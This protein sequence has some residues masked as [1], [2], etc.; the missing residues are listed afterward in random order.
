MVT[1]WI[2]GGLRGAASLGLLFGL[3]ANS[4]W[5]TK[6]VPHV[7]AA[8]CTVTAE[9]I[10][11]PRVKSER[12]EIQDLLA[13]GTDDVWVTG[14]WGD[15]A[16]SQ[17]AFVL[18]REGTQWVDRTPPEDANI[19]GETERQRGL[20]GERAED[21]ARAENLW[22]SGRALL[23][24]TSATD[25]W[26]VS[27]TGTASHW[28]GAGWAVDSGFP[29]RSYTSLSARSETDIW[30]T[31]QDDA[32]PNQAL[33]THREGTVWKPVDGPSFSDTAA[34]W[35]VRALS[36]KNA[37]AV[38]GVGQNKD[39]R[40]LILQW[41]GKTWSEVASTTKK[42]TQLR[43]LAVIGKNDIWAVGWKYK[44]N[45]KR[46]LTMHWDGARWKI[47]PSEVQVRQYY[48]V[49]LT[50]VTA[51]GPDNVWA[52]GNVGYGP[53]TLHWN[54]TRWRRVE[55]KSAPADSGKI[56]ATAGD[57]LWVASQKG[58]VVGMDGHWQDANLP[59]FGYHT[60]VLS[61]LHAFAPDDIW[62]VGDTVQHW[63]GTA[64]QLVTLPKFI[65]E[66]VTFGAISGRVSN[67]LWVL[68]EGPNQ[69]YTHLWFVVHWDGA[70]W[71][72]VTDI[73][74][75][76]RNWITDMAVF[77]SNDILLS[78][79]A[80]GGGS[81]SMLLEHWDGATWTQ[82]VIP[83]SPPPMGRS[84]VR[85]YVRGTHDVWAAGTS[86]L[87]WDGVNWSVSTDADTQALGFVGEDEIWGVGE[88]EF[89][90]FDG[91]GWEAVS[92]ALP[93]NPYLDYEGFAVLAPD[94]VYALPRTNN[95][96][97]P[98]GEKIQHWDGNTW[99]VVD[100][101]ENVAPAWDV[102]VTGDN[103]FWTVGADGMFG[104]S[105]VRR[106]RQVCE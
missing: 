6:D 40:A 60:G 63:D 58:L 32:R 85:L 91:S 37:W 98:Y 75:F 83:D 17:H 102:A 94:N 97:A 21:E 27:E 81:T 53:M 45:R 79:S 69:I 41:D 31:A 65:D 92:S 77:A 73:H 7:L 12:F 52:V 43:A 95:P 86:T 35:D 70:T 55:D 54:G 104:N 33:F 74:N 4:F 39:S 9:S 105:F 89:L 11:L 16:D 48:N 87:H 5:A 100:G 88:K 22:G 44:G 18:H 93:Q 61:R 42:G 68:A 29:S 90:H 64:W 50:S 62:A 84:L 34:V 47:I 13:L 10:T 49:G 106:Y 66:S 2:H 78:G 57:L 38:G 80:Y 51:I 72:R 76:G 103:E 59:W 36:N 56:V 30:L 67:D 25:A 24:G 71:T 96:N 99:Q 1:R 15:Y 82:V 20:N 28:D 101:V 46:P 14:L 23:G 19:R 3:L 8:E 26:Y